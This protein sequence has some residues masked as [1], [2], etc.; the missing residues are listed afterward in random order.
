[1]FHLKGLHQPCPTCLW[2]S[3]LWKLYDGLTLSLCSQDSRQ[4][5]RGG[6]NTPYPKYQ[7]N[8]LRTPSSCNPLSRWY[9]TPA[10]PLGS[11]PSCCL[12]YLLPL[13][14]RASVSCAGS[15]APL[16]RLAGR[17]GMTLPCQSRRA[18]LSSGSVPVQARLPMGIR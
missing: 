15:C 2:C 3:I 5:T 16:V 6:G 10:K 18:E 11:L 9:L 13:L 17:S 1:M 8:H 14:R 4:A 7:V 12:L